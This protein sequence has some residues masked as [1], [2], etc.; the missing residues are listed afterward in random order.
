MEVYLHGGHVSGV[1]RQVEQRKR[2]VDV[3]NAPDTLFELESAKLTIAA[4]DE[5]RYFPIMAID[6][7]AILA[8]I[9]H[10]TREQM[11]HRALLNTAIGRSMT[12]QAQ[13]GFLLPPLYVE[14]TAHVSAG[15]GKLRPNPAVFARFFPITGAAL[16]LPDVDPLEL[17]VVLLNRDNLASISLLSDTRISRVA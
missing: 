5:P 3:L 8:A 10:E 11:R 6:K 9:P 16:Y 1:T 4:G 7:G 13:M 14:G 17:S 15:A 12:R 2:L